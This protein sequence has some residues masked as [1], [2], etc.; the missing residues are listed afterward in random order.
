MIQAHKKTIGWDTN[1]G[2]DEQA[3]FIFDFTME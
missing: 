1:G 3:T 2:V